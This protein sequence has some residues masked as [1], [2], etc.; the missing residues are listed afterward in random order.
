MRRLHRT[1]VEFVDK[2]NSHVC[3]YSPYYEVSKKCISTFGRT[4][5]NNV[6]IVNKHKFQIIIDKLI[7]LSL[8]SLYKLHR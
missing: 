4:V 1:Y 8:S 7:D 5:Y 3:V 6:I 2:D